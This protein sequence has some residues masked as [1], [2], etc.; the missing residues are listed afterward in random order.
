MSELELYQFE[1]LTNEVNDL[2][3]RLFLMGVFDIIVCVLFLFM[4]ICVIKWMKEKDG[5]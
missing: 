5:E 1:E 2:S 3:S 4:F